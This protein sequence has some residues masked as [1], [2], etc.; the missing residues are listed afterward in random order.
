VQLVDEGGDFALLQL[1]DEV[2]IQCRAGTP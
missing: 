2:H 1:R